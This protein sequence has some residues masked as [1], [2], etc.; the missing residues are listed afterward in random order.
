MRTFADAKK[1][2][3]WSSKASLILMISECLVL[4]LGFKTAVIAPGIIFSENCAQKHSTRLRFSP[5]LPYAIG[6]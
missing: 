6:R 4:P 1:C 5:Y 2:L 3:R